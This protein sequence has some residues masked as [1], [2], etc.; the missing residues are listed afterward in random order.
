MDPFRGWRRARAG[1]SGDTVSIKSNKTDFDSTMQIYD[2]YDD[3]DRVT[4]RLV[5]KIKGGCEFLMSGEGSDS[6][7]H[8]WTTSYYARSSPN[9]VLKGSEGAIMTWLLPKKCD[10]QDTMLLPPA[11]LRFWHMSLIMA[12]VLK[13]PFLCQQINSLK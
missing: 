10:P 13:A 3:G 9:R 12:L 6:P 4:D 1:L 8:S 2:R 7:C 5:S 11:S